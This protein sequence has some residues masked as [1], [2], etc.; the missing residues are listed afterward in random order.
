MDNPVVVIS[1]ATGVAATNAAR[2]FARQGAS[3]ALLSGDRSKLNLLAGELNLPP[4]RLQTYAADL[5]DPEM[6]RAAAT[7]INSKFGRADILLHFVGGW[8]GG[9]TLAE[10]PAAELENMLSQHLWTL[11]HLTGML[12]PTM[13][14]N[15]WGRIIIVSSPQAVNPS[16]KMGAYAIGKA[17][18]EALILTLAQEVKD[19]GVTANILHVRSIDATGSGKGTPPDEITAAML[20]L[21]SDAAARINGA[22]IPLL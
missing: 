10:T 8:T 1:G 18:Q 4:A 15:G 22:R 19:S 6:V 12:V 11:F 7:F 20:Y 5:R 16:A 14:H 13:V 3:L 21:C 2:A 9:K 17:A